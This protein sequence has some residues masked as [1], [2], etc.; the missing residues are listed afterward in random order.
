MVKQD[1]MVM[2]NASEYAEYEQM[3]KEIDELRSAL[4][5]ATRSKETKTEDIL[6][7][8]RTFYNIA[9][10]ATSSDDGM[11][12]DIYGHDITVHFHGLYCNCQDGAMAFNYI[13]EG[14]NEC[15]EEWDE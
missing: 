8:M 3:R 9:M 7:S 2:M 5:R 11:E 4:L 14:V 10:S 12:D 13:I 15:A 6:V 1:N